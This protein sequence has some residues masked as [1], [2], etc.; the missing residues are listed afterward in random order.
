VSLCVFRAT[1]YAENQLPVR[2]PSHKKKAIGFHVAIFRSNADSKEVVGIDPSSS[3]IHCLLYR[4]IPDTTNNK[5]QV[6]RGFHFSSVAFSM[7]S[8]EVRSARSIPAIGDL[9]LEWL[10]WQ[11]W[12]CRND[13]GTRLLLFVSGLQS[14]KD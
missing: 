9:R 13:D 8:K 10:S 14:S 3:L 6:F 11:D 4:S 2:Q 5:F 7:V 1:S 12:F